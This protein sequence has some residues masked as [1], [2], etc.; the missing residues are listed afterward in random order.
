MQRRVRRVDNISIIISYTYL[1]HH[2]AYDVF[3]EG[4]VAALVA[5]LHQLVQILLHVLEDKIEGI[6][7]PNYLLQLHHVV[8]RE[9]LE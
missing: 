2:I 5:L 3:G 8:V 4:L 6:V 7:L 1:V 9:L